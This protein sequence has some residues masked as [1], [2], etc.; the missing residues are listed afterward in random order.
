MFDY[1]AHSEHIALTMAVTVFC[2]NADKIEM[3]QSDVHVGETCAECFSPLM[4]IHASV[5]CA[6]FIHSNRL[7]HTQR[8]RTPSG[9]ISLS[10][11]TIIYS[12]VGRNS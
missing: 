11:V 12:T 8:T 5:Q 10:N 2:N 6:C 7:N 3:I 4:S 9:I 1:C